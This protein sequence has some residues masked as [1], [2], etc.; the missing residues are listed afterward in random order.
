MS[1]APWL[2]SDNRPHLIRSSQCPSEAVALPTFF[3]NH[4][5]RSS[6]TQILMSFHV[7]IV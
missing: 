1:A 5:L 6:R 7:W 2:R 4:I 3:K